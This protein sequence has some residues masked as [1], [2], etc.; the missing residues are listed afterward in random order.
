MGF[1]TQNKDGL[2]QLRLD[3]D[4]HGPGERQERRGGELESRFVGTWTC[5][6]EDMKCAKKRRLRLVLKTS[7]EKANML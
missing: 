4:G 3:T 7:G 2:G 5:R 1:I 6:D